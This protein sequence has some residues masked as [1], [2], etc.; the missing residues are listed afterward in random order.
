MHYDVLTGELR[1][2]EG[3]LAEAGMLPAG[4]VVYLDNSETAG[5]LLAQTQRV[6]VDRAAW[7]AERSQLSLE[8]KGSRAPWE[9]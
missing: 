9:I 5:A 2:A 3:G 8:P 6:F 4:E 1:R 7:D